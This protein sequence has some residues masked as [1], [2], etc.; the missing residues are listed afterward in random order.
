MTDK[1]LDPTKPVQTRDGREAKVYEVYPD[2]I[3]GAR[4]GDGGWIPMR[5][6][7]DG[8]RWS[9]RNDRGIVYDLVNV[10]QT[11]ER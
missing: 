7:S 4:R 5:W 9:D 3:L 1:K 8:R 2:Y 6:L 10:P 11:H